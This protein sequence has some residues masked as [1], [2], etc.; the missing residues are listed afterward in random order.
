DVAV[1]L[2]NGF[3]PPEKKE[4]HEI[5]EALIKSLAN[6]K[7]FHAALEVARDLATQENATPVANQVFNGGFEVAAGSSVAGV[8]G[9]QITSLPPAQAALD[10]GQYHA[11]ARSLRLFFRST[12][13]L[14]L[15][16]VAQLIVVEP[17]TRYRLEYYAR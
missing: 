6:A 2:W 1:R 9:W 3:G 15:N 14:A 11:G 17:N 4:Q 13:T 5:G 8:F 16:T 7:R 12:T 10:T